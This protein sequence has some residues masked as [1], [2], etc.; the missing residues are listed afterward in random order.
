MSSAAA[1][2]DCRNGLQIDVVV[3]RVHYY[4]DFTNEKLFDLLASTPALMLALLSISMALSLS[5]KSHQQ[6]DRV[7]THIFEAPLFAGRSCEMPNKVSVASD[8]P[9][10]YCTTTLTLVGPLSAKKALTRVSIA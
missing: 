3:V 10:E 5:L 7:Y 4:G 9:P 2:H 8:I 1:I 6:A